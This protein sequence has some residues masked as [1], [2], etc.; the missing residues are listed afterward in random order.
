MWEACWVPRG[1]RD[2]LVSSFLKCQDRNGI[3]L[4][5]DAAISRI[6]HTS[7]LFTPLSFSLSS[8]VQASSKPRRYHSSLP[9]SSGCPQLG[10]S[11]PA[12][13]P[14]SSAPSSS[15]GCCH[16][17]NSFFTFFSFFLGPSL[18]PS[19]PRP[20]GLL[21]RAPVS[22]PPAPFLLRRASPLSCRAS[23]GHHCLPHSSL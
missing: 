19:P 3:D 17:C 21:E 6:I 2:G 11:L 15:S 23:P 16:S 1:E 5:A 12:S 7:S 14:A 20:L 9:L 18:P 22:P 4:V 8:Q 13:L 10:T